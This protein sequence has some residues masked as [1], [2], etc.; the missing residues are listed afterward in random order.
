MF[1]QTIDQKEHKNNRYKLEP[2]TWCYKHHSIAQALYIKHAAITASQP[3]RFSDLILEAIETPG[4][5][6]KKSFNANLKNTIRDGGS[7]ALY[8]VDTVHISKAL[9][10]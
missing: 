4:Q 7:T 9:G 3:E 6:A 8:A 5:V 2:A 1:S 10:K